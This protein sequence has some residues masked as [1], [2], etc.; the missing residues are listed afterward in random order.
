[1][2]VEAQ[3]RHKLIES[4]LTKI[5]TNEV[6]DITFLNSEEIELEIIQF[7]EGKVF[8][9][10]RHFLDP[11]V[12]ILSKNK[13]DSNSD[14]WQKLFQEFCLCPSPEGNG[15]LS[16][17]SYSFFD[18]NYPEEINFELDWI[19]G[20]SD[21]CRFS[22]IGQSYTLIILKQ[23]LE[24]FPEN[25]NK[26]KVNSNSV[27]KN[28]G[29]VISNSSNF[30]ISDYFQITD[31]DYKGHPVHFQLVEVLFSQ[32]VNLRSRVGF[33][34]AFDFTIKDK[35]FPIYLFIQLKDQAEITK[36]QSSMLD[37]FSTES[38]YFNSHISTKFTNGEISLSSFRQCN[39]EEITGKTQGV[40]HLDFTIDYSTFTGFYF[41]DP[42]FIVSL[43]ALLKWKGSRG[44]F[45]T[46]IF[47]LNRH[48]LLEKYKNL[49]IYNHPSPKEAKDLGNIFI[50]ADYLNYLDKHDKILII[51]NYLATNHNVQSLLEFFFYIETIDGQNKTRKVMSFVETD[52][53]RYLPE[54]FKQ[55]WKERK[56][57]IKKEDWS[58]KNIQFF[59]DLVKAIKTDK[60]AL[61]SR[62]RQ[63]FYSG[64]YN[65]VLKE[66]E[67]ELKKLLSFEEIKK[68]I[69]GFPKKFI[70]DLVGQF[71]NKDL[72]LG[73]LEERPAIAFF[74]ESM[75]KTRKQELNDEY[76]VQQ[77]A[78]KRNNVDITDRLSIR[79]EIDSK[80]KVL[81][82][83]FV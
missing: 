39:L 7:H 41:L 17:Q 31:I 35:K 55:A 40:L 21:V 28:R 16:Y 2:R 6:K 1:M 60:I 23:A 4:I 83:E 62:A 29:F 72:A 9:A 43:G 19:L 68:I 50:L 71:S 47:V 3:D 8:L 27:L 37:L 81:Q 44:D 36:F 20:F 26:Y 13:S 30:V 78:L 65:F 58:Q 45:F 14:R 73:F 24:Q 66:A 82:E 15:V 12:A 80:I 52:F 46:D 53:V 48:L 25:L 67:A 64:F 56:I 74:M 75:S 76:L 61:S 22:L 77:R 10:Y 18:L 70:N 11:E 33:L 63:I 51:Q 79:K 57:Q 5:F 38:K 59:H 54:N 49:G 32:S 69:S 42:E 34:M